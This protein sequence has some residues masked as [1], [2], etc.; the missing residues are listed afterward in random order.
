MSAASLDLVLVNPASRPRVYQSLGKELAAIEPPV[1]VG[2]MAGFVRNRGYSV[3]IIDAEADELTHEEAAQRVVDMKPR[4]L[5]IPVYGHQ[6]SASTQ[7]MP[8]ASSLGSAVKRLAPDLKVIMLGGHVAALP[9]RTLKD[10]AC[11]FVSNGEGLYTLVELI[12]ALKTSHPELGKV[13]DLGYRENGHTVFTAKAPLVTDVD[14]EMP[15]IPWDMLPMK[16]YRAH[17]WHCLGN[18]DGSG[19]L[20]RQPYVA[21]YTTLGCPFK[22][23]FCCIQAPFKSGESE[24]GI[25]AT[26][27]SYR[28][29]S[30]KRV[31]DDL[32]HLVKTYGVRNVKFADEMFVLNKRHVEGICDEIIARKLELNIW[33]YA[34]VDTVKDGMLE[35]LKKA[36]INWLAYGIE[37]AN[38]RVR[39]AVQKG[40]DQED[41]AATLKKTHEAGI[42]VI[43]NY[44]FG[45][46][47]DSLSTMQETLDMAL[48]LNCE[49]AN[50]YC[51]MAYPGSELYRQA[52]AQG[53]RLPETWAG[54][55]QHAVDT[56]PLPTRHL[57]GSEV[58]KFRDQA[59]QVYYN[60]PEYLGMVEK[61]FG[62]ETVGHI[63]Q[64]TKKKLERKFA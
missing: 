61:K 41:I 29:W 2:L 21:I 35:K 13:R 5:A 44:I 45:L 17:N 6:P 37:A 64:M 34:R 53:W 18:V 57:S 60:D 46:P 12:E 16:K 49:F 10:E 14:R 58:L 15:G 30:P 54:Y 25:R 27:N 22:C 24:M 43:G 51:A 40:F 42:N 3:Q 33:A 8:A 48:N 31:V 7:I 50:F 11:D 55:S 63:Q 47:E 28:F 56:L 23:S 32:E 1:W 62:H 52:V 19:E 4:L 20:I 59:F 36:G 26:N 39:D 9:E 38:A